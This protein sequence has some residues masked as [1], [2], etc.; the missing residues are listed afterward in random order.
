MYKDNKTHLYQAMGMAIALS[1]Y[2][3]DDC[4]KGILCVGVNTFWIH[5]SDCHTIVDTVETIFNTIKYNSNTHC[6]YHGCFSLLF[7]GLKDS[8]SIASDARSMK[9]IFFGRF[10]NDFVKMVSS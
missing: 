1:W 2:L 8:G 5:F 10:S 3:D 9:F 6:E 4:N 7:S